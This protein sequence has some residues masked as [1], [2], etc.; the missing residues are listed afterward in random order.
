MAANIDTEL[1][2]EGTYLYY[3]NGQNYSEEN[4]SIEAVEGTNDYLYKSEILSRVDTGEFFKLKVRYQVNKFFAP[5][6]VTIEKSLGER[7]SLERFEVD[8][9]DQVLT[10]TFKGDSEEKQVQRPFG[11]KHF[12]MAPCFV[13]SSLFTLSKKIENS[14]RTPVTF[15]TC[16]NQWD[17]GGVPEDKTLYVQLVTH[18]VDDLVVGGSP[19]SSMKYQIFEH[20]SLVGAG[21][22]S[23]QLWVSKHLGVPY[24]L[25]DKDGTRMTIK[26]FKKLKVDLGK[27]L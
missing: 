18:N 13:T 4:F 19:L 11:A 25:E 24:Q 6:A 16:P 3:Q 12:I 17:F 2:F 26:R 8:Q 1:L 15:I 7:H 21:Q 27:I 9:N 20:D 14:T 23:A 22:P 10:Y 5:L